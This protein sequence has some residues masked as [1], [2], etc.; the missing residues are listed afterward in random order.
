MRY[1]IAT[2]LPVLVLT[3]CSM[4]VTSPTAEKVTLYNDESEMPPSC[5]ALGEVSASV[6]ANTTPC[7]AEVMKRDLRE[8]AFNEFGANAVWLSNRTIAGTRVVGFGI[9]YWCE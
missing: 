8:K 2:L 4:H 5:E 3:G 1:F 6:C 7:P 9:A